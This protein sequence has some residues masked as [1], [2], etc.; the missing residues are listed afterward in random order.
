MFSQLIFSGP[1]APPLGCGHLGFD[2]TEAE[3]AK[4][5]TQECM[6][7]RDCSA[8]LGL[9][10]VEMQLT[11]LLP[12]VYGKPV[13]ADVAVLDLRSIAIEVVRLLNMTTSVDM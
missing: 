2:T 4:G 3:G 5:G 10:G 1:G 8:I 6:T 11:M 12:I 13:E 7:V 9:D